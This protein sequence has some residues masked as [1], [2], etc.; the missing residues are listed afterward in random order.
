MPLRSL[1]VLPWLMGPDAG[2]SK[3]TVRTGPV[4]P[5][6]GPF[7]ILSGSCRQQRSRKQNCSLMPVGIH[8]D[9]DMH[10]AQAMPQR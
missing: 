8:V 9:L 3:A 6:T 2:M 7:V 5:V 10:A 1:C 4:L